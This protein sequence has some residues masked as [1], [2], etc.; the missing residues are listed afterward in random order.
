VGF[1]G[2]LTR[3]QLVL[4]TAV[5]SA[6]V[7]AGVNAITGWGALGAVTGVVAATVSVITWLD[8]RTDKRFK[9]AIAV[10]AEKNKGDHAA[11]RAEVRS[12]VRR[13]TD[14]LV[15]AGVLPALTPDPLPLVQRSRDEEGG[16]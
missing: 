4:L 1:I 10:F 13:L 8:K 2:N 7:A 9:D 11:I 16:G 3:V 14:L 12:E 5:E 6:G 15:T